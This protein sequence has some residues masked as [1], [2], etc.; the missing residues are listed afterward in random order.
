MHAILTVGKVRYFAIGPFV[1]RYI[2]ACLVTTE[3]FQ[4][5]LRKVDGKERLDVCA[6]VVN[7]ASL[8]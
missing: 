4:T 3:K 2:L 6:N 7:L 8:Q 5:N 1:F